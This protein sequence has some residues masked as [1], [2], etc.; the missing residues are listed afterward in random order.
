MPSLL[1]ED[2]GPIRTLTLNR[3]AHRNALTPELQ[4]ELIVALDAVSHSKATRVL[5]L[6][7]AGDAFCAGLDLAALKELAKVQ[8]PGSQPAFELADDSHRFARILRT[9]YELPIP[10]IAQVNGHAIAGGTGLATVCDFTFAV[11]NAKFGYS[12]VKI[13]FIPALVSAFLTLQIGDK[14]ARN[15]LLSGSI[16][17]AEQA[18]ALGLVTEIVEP[19]Q[20]AARV[21]AMA[22]ILI[23]NSPASLCATKALLADQQRAWLDHAILL[24]LSASRRSRITPDFTEGVTAF[25]EKRKPVWKV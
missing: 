11:P 8:Q 1:I 3:P 4:H 2:H 24:A 22:Q 5:I 12:E 21:Q 6:T 10:T 14:R 7:G 20:L 17:T 16:F 13:G 15:L 18:H 23:A 25:L 19:A 9:L